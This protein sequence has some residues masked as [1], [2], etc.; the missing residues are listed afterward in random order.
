M[1]VAQATRAPCVD[2]GDWPGIAPF[3][4]RST[5]VPFQESAK[6]SARRVCGFE[7][8]LCDRAHPLPKRFSEKWNNRSELSNRDAW[9]VAL[10]LTHPLACAPSEFH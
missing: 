2:S 3:C 8:S 9:R 1:P 7:Q 6:R 10:L 4:R 5:I